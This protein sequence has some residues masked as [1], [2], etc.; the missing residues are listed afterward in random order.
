MPGKDKAWELYNL[1]ED[2]SEL[3]NLAG[4]YPEKVKEMEKRYL[5]WEVKAL[6]QP[7]P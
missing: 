5:G 3:V 4:Q 2:R 7:R 6:V 1:N